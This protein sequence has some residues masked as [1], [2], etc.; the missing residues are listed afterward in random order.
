ME[1]SFSDLAGLLGISASGASPAPLHIIDRIRQGLPV[2]T[3]YR[4]TRQIA[5]GDAQFVFR[6]IPKASLARR[7]SRQ[8]ALTGDESDRLARLASIWG[9]AEK[10]WQS[11][12][13]ARNFLFRPH[14]MLDGHKPIDVI[15]QSELGAE[16]VRSI[17]GGLLHGTAA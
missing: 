15:L 8:Q 9:L 12:G 14:P 1:T 10:V 5:P 7:K 16:L 13:A 2:A 11:D 4:V 3:L 6:I 17:L